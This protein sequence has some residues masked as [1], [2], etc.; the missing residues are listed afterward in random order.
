MVD[1]ETRLTHDM[2]LLINEGQLRRRLAANTWNTEN[3]CRLNY[4][5]SNRKEYILLEP[6]KFPVSK[7]M[8]LTL[9]VV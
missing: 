3:H 4:A 2:Q 9:S 8:K 1:I 6:S 7:L 5:E